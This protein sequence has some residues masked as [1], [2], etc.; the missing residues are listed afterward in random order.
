MSAP[1]AVRAGAA[2]LCALLLAAGTSSAQA[3]PP[4]SPTATPSH[5]QVAS[6][7]LDRLQRV[8][9]QMGSVD[10]GEL[11]AELSNLAHDG[12]AGLAS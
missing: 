3:P 7:L 5:A 8:F 10:E 4:G 1:R 9:D 12:R 11:A 2:V 6:Q